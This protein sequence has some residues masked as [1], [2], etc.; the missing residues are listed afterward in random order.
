MIIKVSHQRL[1]K[2]LAG[3]GVGGNILSWMTEYLVDGKQGVQ[4]SG[5]F[6]EWKEVCSGIPQGSILGPVLFVVYINDMPECV[7]SDIYLFAD[8]TKICREIKTE[9]D[10]DILQEDLNALQEWSKTWLMPFHPQ[11][12]KCMKIHGYRQTRETEYF[13][14]QGGE[15][16]TVIEKTNQE[17]DLG[18]LIDGRLTFEDHIQDK[19]NKANRIM[20]MIR[21]S[22]EY[23][24]IPTFRTLFKAIVRPHLEYAQSVWAPH[25]KKDIRTVENVLRRAS[26]MVP[27][28][29]RLTYEERL[30]KLDLPT[31]VYRRWRGDMIE[32]WKVMNQKYDAR[33]N[34]KFQL[35]D[36]ITR[37]NNK[38]LFK[39]RCRTQLRQN[40]FQF[41]VINVRNSLCR[42]VV[43][44]DS[45]Y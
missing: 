9:E 11:K 34:I 1:L 26:K 27:G 3:Y 20:G 21:R 15:E 37:G 42:C 29:H 18:V 30:R 5:T 17:K 32:V 14:Q 16:E 31:M 22:F 39:L 28:L 4:I 12:C 36:G 6:S 35:R 41:R 38:K 25:R 13:M 7:Q 40:I 33:V 19:V 45:I 8:D 24:D 2:K 44:A 43:E 10:R 23:L